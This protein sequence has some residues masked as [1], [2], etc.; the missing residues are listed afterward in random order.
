MKKAKAKKSEV[1]EAPVGK[2]VEGPSLI[3]HDDPNR[4]LKDYEL[5]NHMNDILRAETVKSNP[6]IMKQLTP[7]MEKKMGQM[8]KITSMDELKRVA[9]Q[10]SMEE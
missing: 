7:H 1:S 10:K 6:N 2:P 9:K 4:E 5:D 8:K 3:D